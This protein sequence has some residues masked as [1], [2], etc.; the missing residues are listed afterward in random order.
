MK[1]IFLVLA[2]ALFVFTTFALEASAKELKI[3]YV[4]MQKIFSEYKK[5]K[6]AEAKL[7]VKGRA[8]V[9]EREKMV[10]DIRRLKDEMDLLSE[11]S[12]EEKQ[13]QMDEK[14]KQL[15]DYDR[16]TRNELLS[17]R[18]DVIKDISKDIDKAITNYGKKHDYDLILNKDKRVLLYKTDD[19]DITESV[20]R[21]LNK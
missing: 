6:D 2:V 3:G 1:K 8:K 4:D 20:M 19:L 11:K 18:E 17:Q 13:E 15:Q 16:E 21:T 9:E 7:E 5:T 14:I 10:E 12:K